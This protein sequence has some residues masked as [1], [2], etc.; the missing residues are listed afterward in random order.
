MH[1]DA[2]RTGVEEQGNSIARAYDTTPPPT[3]VVA[4]GECACIGGI[5]RES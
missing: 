5:S 1:A 3:L 4:A 2:Y